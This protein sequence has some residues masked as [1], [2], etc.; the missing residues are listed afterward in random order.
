MKTKN[1][2][3]QVENK[4][5]V[6]KK[7][8]QIVEAAAELFSKKGYHSTT[9]RDIASASGINLSYLYQYISS[10]D[11]ILYLFYAN[12]YVQ[13]EHIYTSLRECT[14]EDPVAQ[15]K[16]FINSMFEIALKMSKE[17]L[18][19]IT[20]GRHLN[21]DSLHAILA[22]EAEMVANLEQLIIRG[23]KQGVFKTNDTHL[24]ANVIQHL[25]TIIPLRGWNIRKTN[26]FK[27]IVTQISSLVLHS[28]GVFDEG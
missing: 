14:D 1:I 25:L 2:V 26:T 27:S 5:L 20:E 19:V 3:S 4:E 13:W 28:L 9:M 6:E 16:D 10:K 12:L 21:S 11:D 15:L 22:L 24:A 17:V 8:L 7:Q 18:T 23:V